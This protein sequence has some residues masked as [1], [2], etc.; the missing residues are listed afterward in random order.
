MSNITSNRV[1]D[2]INVHFD[3]ELISRTFEVRGQCGQ[4]F[5]QTKLNISYVF[6]IQIKVFLF[7]LCAM[8]V[9]VFVLL[10]SEKYLLCIRTTTVRVD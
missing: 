1:F 9:Q 2:V 3:I 10:R 5:L 8:N 6:L 4:L 7:C